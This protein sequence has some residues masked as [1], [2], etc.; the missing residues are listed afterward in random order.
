MFM[1]KK[2]FALFAALSL[3]GALT[4]FAADKPATKKDTQTKESAKMED[5]LNKGEFQKAVDKGKEWIEVHTKENKLEELP[6]EFWINLSAAYAGLKD[7]PNALDAIEKAAATPAGMFDAVVFKN[8]A[9]ILHEM[10]QDDKVA[11]T[12]K[13]ILTIE[14]DN[15]E[16]KWSLARLLEE[17][18]KS[19]DALKYYDEVIAVKPDFNDVAFDVG[20]LLSE[21]KDYDKALAYF[22]KAKTASPGNEKV[23][24]A[25][26]QTLIK[27]GKTKEAIPALKEYLAV[28]KDDTKRVAVTGQLGSCQM[29]EKQFKEAISTWDDILKIRPNDEKAL[30]NKGACLVDLKDYP[31]AISTL[32]TY[33]G[34]S[35][36][37][38]KKKEVAALLKDL[39]GG[40]K[41]K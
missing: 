8:K 11:E 10:K 19:E 24:L 23:L 35:K 17:Q 3:I 15:L 21:K 36:N 33:M 30:I 31:A 40:A 14:P 25:I 9:A 13:T 20:V 34:V 5:L 16:V 6:K 39:K 18:K 41:R 26:S 12:F 29:K 38:E 27:A 2:L 1:R 32:E 22:E 28:T 37:E 7:Y 4:P